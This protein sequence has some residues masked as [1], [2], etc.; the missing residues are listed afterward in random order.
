MKQTDIPGVGLVTMHD[1]LE[2]R[3]LRHCREGTM[4]IRLGGADGKTVGAPIPSSVTTPKES[5]T[6]NPENPLPAIAPKEK[7]QD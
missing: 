1:Q 5:N 7:Q 4:G 2:G 6:V 3:E